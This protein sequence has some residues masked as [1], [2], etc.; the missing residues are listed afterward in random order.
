[1]P[2]VEVLP[3][4]EGNGTQYVLQKSRGASVFSVCIFLLPSP[5]HLPHKGS[6]N[7]TTTYPK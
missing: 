2:K 4:V 5:P 3:K 6:T 1:L 7:Y